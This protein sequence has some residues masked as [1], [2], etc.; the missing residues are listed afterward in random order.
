MKD[1][2]LDENHLVHGGEVLRDRFRR[3]KMTIWI[4]KGARF[5][6]AR[7]LE[8]QAAMSDVAAFLLS[9]A[10]ASLSLV[11]L[12]FAESFSAFQNKTIGAATV[13]ITFF[14][15]LMSLMNSSKNYGLRAYVLHRCGIELTDLFQEM[16]A[17]DDL[18]CMSHDDY[19]RYQR[20]YGAILITNLENH[21]NMDYNY[22]QCMNPHKFVKYFET[23]NKFERFLQR[24]FYQAQPYVSA[25]WYIFVP[26]L[27]LVGAGYALGSGSLWGSP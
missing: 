12:V 18:D 3:L 4:T 1:N 21:S 5:N 19:L 8:R 25:L 16:E 11:S 7:R 22:F 20:R 9:F 15:M 10:V 6:A 13:I 27:V 24:F 23:H 2:A 14:I 26:T 17:V